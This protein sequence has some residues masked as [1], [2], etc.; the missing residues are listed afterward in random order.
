MYVCVRPSVL[1][2]RHRPWSLF[3]RYHQKGWMDAPGRCKGAIIYTFI[4]SSLFF[5]FFFLFSQ[6]LWRLGGPTTTIEERTNGRLATV[7]GVVGIGMEGVGYV[8]RVG[9]GGRREIP[10]GGGLILFEFFFF[11]SLARPAA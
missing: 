8:L 2:R 9:G 1:C 3:A 11:N 6:V 10:D 5:F 4:E 7:R